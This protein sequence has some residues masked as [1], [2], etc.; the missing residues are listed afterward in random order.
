MNPDSLC[1]RL[2]MAKYCPDGDLMK[3]REGPGISYSWRSIVR[4]IQAL[5][6]GIIWRVGN[7]ESIKIWEDPWIPRG[8]PRR[9]ITPKGAVILSKVLKLIDPSTGSWDV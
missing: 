5:K 4:G 9:P 8:T 6:E 2:L 1:A 7:G 3:V